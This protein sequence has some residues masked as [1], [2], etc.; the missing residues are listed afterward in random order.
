[1]RPSNASCWPIIHGGQKV[2]RPFVFK[3]T[4]QHTNNWE[5][6]RLL[7]QC[8]V[9]LTIDV[10]PPRYAQ[11]Y[12]ILFDDNQYDVTIGN[13]HGCSCVYFVKMLASSLGAHGA[14][15][16]CKHVYHILETIMLCGL[17]K[18]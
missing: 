13:F 2:R 5:T 8:I 1:V 6:S 9:F 14:Y 15:V 11:I 18:E 10:L 12:N 16:Q 3:I 17:T 7:L 4:Q